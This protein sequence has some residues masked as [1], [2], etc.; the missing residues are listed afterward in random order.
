MIRLVIISIIK[1][2]QLRERDD[3]ELRIG[4]PAPDFTLTSG[5]GNRISLSDYKGKTNVVLFFIREFV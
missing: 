5:A 4:L 1:G 2:I 3:H